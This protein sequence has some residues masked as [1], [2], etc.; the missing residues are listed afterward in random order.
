MTVS[1][2]AASSFAGLV[3]SGSRLRGQVSVVIFSTENLGSVVII[4]AFSRWTGEADLKE[5][6]RN[7]RMKKRELSH[8]D[9]GSGRKVFRLVFHKSEVDVNEKCEIIKVL[10]KAK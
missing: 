6:I 5:E 4:E 2:A 9:V 8:E 7:G 3:L 10:T 1:T